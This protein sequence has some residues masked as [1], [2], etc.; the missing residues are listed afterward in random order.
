MGF[1]VI[2]KKD[3]GL[4]IKAIKGTEQKHDDE[5]AMEVCFK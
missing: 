3:K 1:T 2:S 5:M 4:G